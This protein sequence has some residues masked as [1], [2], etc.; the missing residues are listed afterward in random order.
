[1]MPYTI[2]HLSVLPNLTL[3]LSWAVGGQADVQLSDVIGHTH[4][5]LSLREPAAFALASV[6]EDGLSV[7]WPNG[8]DV[9]A[10][11]LWQLA[12]DQAAN[13]RV[14]NGHVLEPVSKQ[15]DTMLA[16]ITPENSHEL[17]D[18]GKPVGREV[19]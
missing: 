18:F 12:L 13:V 5:L 11:R 8:L 16:G 15:G 2:Q 10:S 1:M 7:T 9:S 6:G 3:R 19:W 4:G 17:V 14:E